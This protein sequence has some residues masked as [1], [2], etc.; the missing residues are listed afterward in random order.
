MA[1]RGIDPHLLPDYA[2][3]WQGPEWLI[4]NAT[5]WPTTQSISIAEN[6]VN[7]K[8]VHSSSLSFKSNELF[9]AN[10]HVSSPEPPREVWDL[11]NEYSSL[12][13]LLRITAY[14]LR[15]VNRLLI[16]AKSRLIEKSRLLEAKIICSTLCSASKEPT[17]PELARAKQLWVFLLQNS[18]YSNE[19]ESLRSKKP[20]PKRSLLLR[21]NR[22]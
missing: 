1:S 15:F 17:L 22:F 12:S 7:S 2:L 3:W 6:L 9:S 20:L 16:R 8:S 11:I 14:C 21:L 5:P 18:H 10:H 13:K 19:I 4:S